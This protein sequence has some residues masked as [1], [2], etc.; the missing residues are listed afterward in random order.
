MIK[1][2][3]VKNFCDSWDNLFFIIISNV[4][5]IVAATAMYF[6]LTQSGDVNS[7]LPNIAFI[8]CAGFFMVVTFAWGVNAEKI[9]EFNTPSFAVFF[10]SLKTVFLTAFCFGALLAIFILA[11][12][13]GIRYYLAFFVS[14]NIIG[15]LFTAVIAW[16]ML[17]VF[18]AM[19]WFVPLYFLQD[20]NTFLKCL[21]KSFII[22]FD[23]AAFSILLFVYNLILFAFT[24]ISFGLIP[25]INGITLSSTNA[26]RIRLYKYDW[27]E[28][29]PEYMDDREKRSQIPWDELIA[30]DKEI[31]GPRNLASFL[32][33]WR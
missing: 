26:L 17:V 20:E 27:L 22:F 13:N 28:E 6:V 3:F 4:F 5:T 11:G 10:K 12:V 18:I 29:N 21:R 31:L 30:E 33:P 1:F 19:Q 9:A 16:F 14:G 15:I 7:Y 8:V 32:F 2:W 24:I 23:N 25:G